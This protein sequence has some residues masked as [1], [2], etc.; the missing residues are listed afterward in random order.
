ML[1]S[2]SDIFKQK[3]KNNNKIKINKLLHEGLLL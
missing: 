2:Y 1:E 3:K